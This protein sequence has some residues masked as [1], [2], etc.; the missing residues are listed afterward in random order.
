MLMLPMDI[1]Q[2]PAD[3][4]KHGKGNGVSIDPA[5]VSPLNGQFPH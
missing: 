5:D 4:A 2:M 1:H 3:V